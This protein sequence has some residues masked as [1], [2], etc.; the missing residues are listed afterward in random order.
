MSSVGTKVYDGASRS[1][2]QGALRRQEIV[3]DVVRR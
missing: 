2:L 1:V 3:E